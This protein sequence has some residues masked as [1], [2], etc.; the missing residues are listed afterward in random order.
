MTYEPQLTE[1]PDA[2]PHVRWCGRGTAGITGCPLSRFF[3]HLSPLRTGASLPCFF[4]LEQ[5]AALRPGR[6]LHGRL[7]FVPQVAI[8]A[9]LFFQHFQVN[10]AFGR[11]ETSEAWPLRQTG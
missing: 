1:P 4:F 2:D 10:G 11:D 9:R 3:L 6:L 7:D 5:S 8:A